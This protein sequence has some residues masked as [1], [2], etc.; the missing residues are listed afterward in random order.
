M[1]RTRTSSKGEQNSCDIPAASEAE[2]DS[3]RIEE[4]E[5]DVI[6]SRLYV[7]VL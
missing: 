5:D 6:T 4:E 2:I 1:V 7:D 3:R